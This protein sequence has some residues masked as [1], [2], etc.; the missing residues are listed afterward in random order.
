MG[1][2]ST[3]INDYNTKA[4]YTSYT[5]MKDIIDAFIPKQAGMDEAIA[6]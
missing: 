3:E 4:P 1:A 6:P 2:N 5:T